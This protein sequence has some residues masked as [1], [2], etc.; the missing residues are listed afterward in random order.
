MPPQVASVPGAFKRR[1]QG[2]FFAIEETDDKIVLP[3]ANGV[4]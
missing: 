1:I 2:D 3:E 4:A